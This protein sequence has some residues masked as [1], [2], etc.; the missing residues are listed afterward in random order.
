MFGR[1]NRI[2]E[3]ASEIQEKPGLTI[4]EDGSMYLHWNQE[5]DFMNLANVMAL[6]VTGQLNQ[7]VVNAI[8]NK[9]LACTLPNDN[10]RASSVL[11]QFRAV[12]NQLTGQQ[13]TDMMNGLA[14]SEGE[15]DEVVVSAQDAFSGEEEEE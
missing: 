6:L 1:K 15:E 2:E 8:V 5:S 3:F 7:T 10:I 13:I 4:Y 9:G 11:E 14:Q 12:V